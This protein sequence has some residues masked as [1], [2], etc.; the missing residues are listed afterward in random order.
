[1]K[2][3]ENGVLLLFVAL[4]IDLFFSQSFTIQHDFAC[5][6]LDYDKVS[7]GKVLAKYYDSKNT[8]VV[9]AAGQLPYYSGWKSIDA[10]GLYDEHVAHYG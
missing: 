4:A 1:M 8:I 7:V 10:C 3:F 2:L 9:Q 5:R 6:T